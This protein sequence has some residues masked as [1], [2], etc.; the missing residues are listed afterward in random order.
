MIKLT[1]ED[2]W[3]NEDFSND[4]EEFKDKQKYVYCA[5]LPWVGST[6]EVQQM[7]KQI[8]DNQ[9]KAEK[10]N[11]LFE[12]WKYFPIERMQWDEGNPNWGRFFAQTIKDQEENKRL[13]ENEIYYLKQCKIR[14]E[15]KEIVNGIKACVAVWPA[16]GYCDI[17]APEDCSQAVTE[18]RDI[19]NITDEGD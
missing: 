14:D 18:V 12:P 1:E 10:W 15:L 17:D 19:L 3:V 4:Y 16:K 6:E 9:E 8:L 11:E 5:Q 7:K 13:K 2:I